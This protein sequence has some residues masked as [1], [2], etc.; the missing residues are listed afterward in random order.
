M[1]AVISIYKIQNTIPIH[2]KFKLTCDVA[3][4]THYIYKREMRE[5]TITNIFI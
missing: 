5:N 4:K 3:N 1:L 2:N